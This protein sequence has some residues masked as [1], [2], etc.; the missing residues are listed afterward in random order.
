MKNQ[1]ITK[2]I[3]VLGCG[4]VG[5][6]IAALLSEEGQHA[7]T[8]DLTM[9]D[10]NKAAFALLPEKL[11]RQTVTIDVND[12]D[13]LVALMHTHDAIINALPFFLTEQ[14]ASAAVVGNCHYLDLTEDVASTKRVRE[15]S[16]SAEIAFIPQCGLAPGYIS[17]VGY[18]MAQKFDTLRDLRLKVG[19]LPR[20]PSNALKY[21]L[22]WSTDGLVNEYL[23]PCESV[24]GG[25]KTLVPAL[26]DLNEFVL[27]GERYEAFNTS[28]GLGSLADTLAGQVE[29]LSYQSIRYPGHN[30]LIRVLVN[31]LRLGERPSLLVDILEHA[32]PATTQ[33]VVLIYVSASGMRNG[34]FMQETYR[35]KVFGRELLGNFWSGIQ[36]TTGAAICAALDLLC[37]GKL[38]QKGLI[39]QEEIAFD[40]FITNRFGKYYHQ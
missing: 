4:K 40:D 29:N 27:D 22:T 25:Q 16:D 32:I 26:Q 33:D 20:F 37:Q 3:L 28:G 6:M 19:A 38:P 8:Y 9:A 7:V 5:Q 23:H 18:H 17:I 39:R 36:I 24:V 13:R 21:N 10:Q 1:A 31:D 30:A 2:K 11:R 14:V 15:L 34:R 12:H 35:R